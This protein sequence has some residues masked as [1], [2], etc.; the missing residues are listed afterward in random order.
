MHHYTNS[1]HHYTNFANVTT[2]EFNISESVGAWVTSLNLSIKTPIAVPFV[3]EREPGGV[4]M[5]S[6]H[7]CA[8]RT[9]IEK[10]LG[11]QFV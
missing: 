7:R 6:S 3:G 8:L 9:L 1:M 2:Q 10:L 4:L 11:G 5:D